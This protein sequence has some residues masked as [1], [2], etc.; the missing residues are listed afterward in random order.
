[1]TVLDLGQ[2]TA[3]ARLRRLANEREAALTAY[4]EA[5]GECCSLSIPSRQI[6]LMGRTHYASIC[7]RQRARV[8]R[9]QA[10]LVE[11]S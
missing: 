8:A 2:L 6:A 3:L 4:Y 9:V 10:E 5:E 7:R 1:M 11:A